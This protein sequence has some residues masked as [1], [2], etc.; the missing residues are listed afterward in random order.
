MWRGAAQ[1]RAG[2]ANGKV[3]VELKDAQG[4]ELRVNAEVALSASGLRQVCFCES[5]P[6]QTDG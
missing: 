3:H 6:P 1:D 2:K 5:F 4:G